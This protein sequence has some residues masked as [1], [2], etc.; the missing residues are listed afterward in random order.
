[1][2]VHVGISLLEFAPMHFLLRPLRYVFYRILEFKRRQP[3]TVPVL[4]AAYLTVLLVMMNAAVLVMLVNGYRGM[5]LLPTSPGRPPPSFA[6]LVLACLLGGYWVV[7]RMW[8][9][10]RGYEKLQSEFS[11]IDRSLITRRN[12]LFWLYIVVSVL[13]PFILIIVWHPH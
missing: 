8:V 12:V 2:L 6:V 3:G 1:M 5:P 11:T 10:D 13:A 9:A 4:V 7:N